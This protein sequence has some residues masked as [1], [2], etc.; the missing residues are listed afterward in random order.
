[1]TATAAWATNIVT[2]RGMTVGPRALRV[3]P[4]AHLRQCIGISPMLY[5]CMMQIMY[6]HEEFL[7]ICY[8]WFCFRPSSMFLHELWCNRN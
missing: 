8:Y 2:T 4:N 3:I 7:H 5:C 6:K 1:M